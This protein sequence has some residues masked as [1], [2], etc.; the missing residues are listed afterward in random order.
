MVNKPEKRVNKS[1]VRRPKRPGR[2]KKGAGGIDLARIV[3]TA[4]AIVDRD[5]MAALSTR[6][7]AAALDVKSPALYWYVQSKD[8]LLSL[9]MEQ[10]LQNSLDD[11][12]PNLSWSDWLGYVARRQRK[13]LLSHRDGGLI[14]SLAAPTERLRTQIFP[15]IM[16]PLLAAGFHPLQASAA[17]GGL[18]ALVLGWVIYEQRPA[19]REF[20]ETFHTPS[21]GFD[22]ALENFV[23]G[24]AAKACTQ[25]PTAD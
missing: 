11:A 17:A 16:E 24:I 3:T 23:M 18:A 12:P 10:L 14:A 19:T 5:G 7:L 13:L 25:L 21:E 2:P 4:W 15:R 1:P 20:V 6:T 22:L 9:M 8:E